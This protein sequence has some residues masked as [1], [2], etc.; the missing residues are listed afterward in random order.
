M[1]AVV[2]LSTSTE[3]TRGSPGVNRGLWVTTMTCQRRFLN[4]SP[5]TALPRSSAMSGAV[6]C[7]GRR[8]MADSVPASQFCCEPP[9]A[10]GTKGSLLKEGIEE[11]RRKEQREGAGRK[12]DVV[13]VKGPPAELG[14]VLA[15]FQLFS[16]PDAGTLPGPTAL[17]SQG[18]S[19]QRKRVESGLRMFPPILPP[20]LCRVTLCLCKA[21]SQTGSQ[22]T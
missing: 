12:G 11:G 6:P 2:H 8:Y 5:C 10:G 20:L 9:T 19:S 4:C 14:R 21:E 3:G 13:P 15:P 17:P 1:R 22:R 16:S 7:A 18:A